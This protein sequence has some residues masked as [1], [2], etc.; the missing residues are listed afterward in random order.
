[1]AVH[2]NRRGKLRQAGR[3]LLAHVRRGRQAIQRRRAGA[4]DPRDSEVSR[5]DERLQPLAEH[6]RAG[7][8]FE[9][10]WQL[11]RFG[12]LQGI[13]DEEAV[14]T[15]GAWCKRQ[16]FEMSFVTR[17]GRKRPCRLPGAQGQ[18]PD[19]LTAPTGPSG[20]ANGTHSRGTLVASEPFMAIP[21]HPKRG[22]VLWCNFDRNLWP[23]MIKKRPAVVFTHKIAQ[24]ADVVAM[25]PL[26][27]TA[28]AHIL[29]FHCVLEKHPFP[30]SAGTK[31]WAKCDMIQT[32][33][34]ERLFGYW[35]KEVDGKRDYLNL[36][37]SDADFLQIRKC[38]L[39][40]L[41]FGDLTKHLG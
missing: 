11:V 39:H 10:P 34:F 7:R 5:L 33:S 2:G 26:S 21:F 27:T 6:V 18:A 20:L 16:G 19:T 4:V 37:V 14:P 9:S 15:L 23:E 25:V 24:R 22:Q 28:P 1:M 13:S 41:G 35:E 40:G 17:A 12:N 36:F 32:V 8:F 31:C 3:K 38:V 29:D 30:A